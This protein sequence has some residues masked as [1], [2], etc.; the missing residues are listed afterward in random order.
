MEFGHTQLIKPTTPCT[1]PLKAIQNGSAFV[2][3]G[4]MTGASFSI[5]LQS[6]AE[7]FKE[8][9]LHFNPRTNQNQ[10]VM[11]SADESI[12]AHEE[13]MNIGPFGKG[14]PFSVKVKCKL[15]GFQINVNGYPIYL[16]G[17]RKP[18]Q[19]IDHLSVCG[20]VHVTYVAVL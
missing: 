1:L 13:R 9:A 10:I 2:V 19:N 7:P 14:E 20:D 18:P 15:E 4:V 3:N 8:V 12:W 11:N 16:F 5:N 17:H 6:S